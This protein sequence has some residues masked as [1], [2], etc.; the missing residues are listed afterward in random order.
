MQ[1]GSSE[2]K[3]GRDPETQMETDSSTAAAFIIGCLRNPSTSFESINLSIL[4]HEDWKGPGYIMQ[5]GGCWVRNEETV[6]ITG[7]RG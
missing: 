4:P 1:S 5:S 6:V 7:R 2:R 3:K